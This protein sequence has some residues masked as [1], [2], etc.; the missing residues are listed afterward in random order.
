MFCP[1][2]VSGHGDAE[3]Y[4]KELTV[5][6]D[7]F[8]IIPE[9]RDSECGN[10]SSAERGWLGTP[11]EIDE[12]GISKTYETEVLVIGCGTGGMFTIAAAAEDGA[13]VI[14]IDCFPTGVGV[15][16][17]IGAIGSRY[18]KEYGTE[19]DKFEFITMATQY[20]SGRVNQQLIKKWADHS[21][22]V[23][24]WYGDLLARRGVRLWH[25]SGDSNDSARYKH[26]PTGH[27][28][29]WKGSD[30]GSGNPL[31]GNR[32][33]YDYALSKGAEF[34]YST[35]MVRLDQDGSG[36]VTGCTAV[37]R[38]GNYIRY[39]ASKGTV[40]CTGGYSLNIDMLE[41]LQPW[42]VRITAGNFS[43]AG[44]FGDGIK[45]CLWAGAAMDETQDSMIFDRTA[46]R[47]D[48]HPGREAVATIREEGLFWMGSQPWLKVNK[49]GL[50]FFNE[51][52]TYDGI[53]RANEFNREHVHYTIFDGNWAAYAQQFKMHGC[54][55]LYPFENGADPKIPCQV[56]AGVM[57]P[58]LIKD[59]YVQQADT[60]EELAGKLGLPAETFRKTVDRYNALA[61]SGEDTDFGKEAHRLSPVDTPPFYGARTAGSI[62]CTLNGIHIDTDCR[63]LD[64]RGDPVPGLYVNGNDSGGFFANS[65]P[66]LATGL[67]CGRTVTFG[68]LIGK[69]LA[70]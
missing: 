17:D 31:N 34:H 35:K 63:A 12:S 42:T 23:M 14:G 43:K 64:V 6:N 5:M 10:D 55:R 46:L 70:K 3:R 49:D 47:S 67:A 51:S 21:G 7:I 29:R 48:Q 9:I 69:L 1:D 2:R 13:K 19:I 58:G 15:R 25:Q 56:I 41:A 11:P 57:L 60:I 54:C 65:Y 24:D 68:Y 33:L 44:A 36:T 4:E 59:G 22:A 20:A 40:V 37:D 28:P 26:Y 61:Y 27:A 8:R 39:R 32:V 18:Q 66:N 45:A 50:R 52:G 62:L 53:I 16:D 30:D 38:D